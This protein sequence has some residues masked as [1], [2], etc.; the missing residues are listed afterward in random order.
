M[1]TAPVKAEDPRALTSVGQSDG[2]R[3]THRETSLHASVDPTMLDVG[4]ASTFRS[5]SRPDVATIMSAA[6]ERRCRSS[7]IAMTYPE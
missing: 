5:R 1:S 3:T 7:W 4:V 2:L 6:G